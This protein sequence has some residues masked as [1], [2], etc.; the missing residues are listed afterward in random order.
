V[1]VM[2]LEPWGAECQ[3]GGLAVENTLMVP[4]LPEECKRK[5]KI[6]EEGFAHR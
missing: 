5:V 6:V 4:L 3:P 2:R 1:S